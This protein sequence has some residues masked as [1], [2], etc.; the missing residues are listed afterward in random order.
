MTRAM[1]R[2]ER[3]VKKVHYMLLAGLVIIVLGVGVLV[4]IIF[5]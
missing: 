4:Y 2:A 1:A 5:N 3:I